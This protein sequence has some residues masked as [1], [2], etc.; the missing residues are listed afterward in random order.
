MMSNV[1]SD[2]FIYQRSPATIYTPH[3]IVQVL[4]DFRSLVADR[5]SG[6]VLELGPYMGG[7]RTK[8]HML[9]RVSLFI[10]FFFFFFFIV[11][12]LEAKEHWQ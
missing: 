2:C 8:Y 3:Q 9:D 10:Y 12:R 7:A 6:T 11:N 4:P 1:I 5:I